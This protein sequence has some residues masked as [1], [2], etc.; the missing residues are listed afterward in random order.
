MSLNNVLGA[1][2]LIGAILDAADLTESETAIVLASI[3]ATGAE[4]QDSVDPITYVNGVANLAKLEL[5]LS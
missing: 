3:I 2:T 5:V 4:T 1:A